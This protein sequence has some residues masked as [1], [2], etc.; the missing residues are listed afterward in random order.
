MVYHN[1][2]GNGTLLHFYVRARA[3]VTMVGIRR[4]PAG[5]QRMSHFSR[6]PSQVAFCIKSFAALFSFVLLRC[7]VACSIFIYYYTLIV[8]SK[9]TPHIIR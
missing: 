5:K 3:K 4:M 7:I 6:F 1:R 2:G 8:V 9:T